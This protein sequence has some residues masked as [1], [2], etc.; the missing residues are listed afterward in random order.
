M[1]G[2]VPLG[3]L[4]A[5]FIET[6]T[7]SSNQIKIIASGTT[8]K[9]VRRIQRIWQLPNPGSSYTLPTTVPNM[10]SQILYSSPDPVIGNYLN[11]NLPI[12]N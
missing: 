5:F 9:S 12:G 8:T 2:N 10:S 3:M 1:E 7:T 4:A 6:S 11:P